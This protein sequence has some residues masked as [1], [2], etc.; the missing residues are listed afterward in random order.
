[1]KIIILA[2]CV[3]LAASVVFS[4]DTTTWSVQCAYVPTAYSHTYYQATDPY[5]SNEFEIGARVQPAANVAV[6]LMLGALYVTGYEDDTATLTIRRPPVYSAMGKLGVLY[7]L[8]RGERSVL[9]ALIHVGCNYDKT[10][11]NNP[12]DNNAKTSYKVISPFG[13]I[14]LEPSIALTKHVVFFTRI[15]LKARYNPGTQQYELGPR[16]PVTSKQEYVL[17]KK[18]N[19]NMTYG[20][21][22]FCIGFRYQFKKNYW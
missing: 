11:A 2:C 14:G 3:M 22:G 6:D 9:G 5:L 13:F 16:D 20:V 4:Q 12:W 8:H 19:A 7:E 15:G 18:E 17:V 1:M 21:D 10:Y